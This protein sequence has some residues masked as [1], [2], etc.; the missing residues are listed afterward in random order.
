MGTGEMAREDMGVEGSVEGRE[1]REETGEWVNVDIVVEALLCW[2]DDEGGWGF[3][4]SIVL[5][6]YLS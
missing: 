2:N 6:I 1:V 4:V 3:I 5:S